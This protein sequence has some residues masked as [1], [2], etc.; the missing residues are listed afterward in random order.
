MQKQRG[1]I[2]GLI[3]ILWLPFATADPSV[4]QVHHALEV[5]LQPDMAAIEVRDTITLPQGHP[6]S[7]IFSLHPALQP[8]LQGANARLVE[9]PQRADSK[10]PAVNPPAGLEPRRYRLD[11]AGGE[12]RFTLH[13]SGSIAHTLHSRGE[14]YARSFEETRGIISPQGVF[15]SGASAW[16]PLLDDTLVTFDLEVSL[17]EAWKSM[18]QGESLDPQPA[19]GGAP[20]EHW[21]DTTPQEEIYLIAGPFT[22]YASVDAGIDASINTSTGAG[23]TAMVLLREPD[24]ALAQK[25]LDATHEYIALYD[26]LIG[27][28]PFKKFALVE[29]FWETGYGMPSFTLLGSRVIRFPFILSSSYPH[30]ILH[31]WWG[32]GVY[33]DYDSGNWAEGLTSYLADH[34]IKE[35]RGAGS[36]YRRNTLQ[37]YTDHVSHQRDFPLTAFRSRHSARTEAVGYGK[38]LMLFHMLRQQLGDAVFQ[39]G[40]QRFYQRHIFRVAGFSEVQDSFA[41]VAGEPLDDFFQQWVQRT[42]APQLGIGNARAQPEGDGYRLTAVIE[43]TQAG[44]VYHVS[45]PV[46]IHMDGIEQAYQTRIN[47]RDR[48]QTLSLML[49]ARPTRLDVDPEFDVFRRLHRNEIPPAVSQ[50]MGAERVLVVIAEQT[51]AALKQAYQALAERWQ[52]EKPGQVDV[53]FDRELQQLPD[54]RAVWLFG[55]QNRLR[56]QLN[57]ALEGY[58]FVAS[59][60]SVRIAGT[61]LSAATHSLVLL[62]RQPQA[63]DQALGWLAADSAAALPGLGRKLPHYG[64]YS[65]LGF[66]GMEPDNVLKGQWPVVDSPLSVRVQQDDGT[67]VSFNPASLAPRKALVAPVEQ[68]SVARMQQDIAF[69]ADASLAGR[70]LGTPQLDR[71]ADYI[72]QQFKTAGLQPGGDNGSYYQAWQQPVAAL[73]ANVA[74]KNVIAVLP[75]SDPRYQGQ[76]L[77]IAAHYDHMGRGE[78]NGRRE[79]RGLIHPGA[80]D[81]ASGIAVM[82]ELAR[83]LKG[84]PLP[85]TLVFVAFTGEETG[86]LGSRHYVRHTEAYPIDAVIGMLNLDT[87][88]RLGD[89]PLILL[90]S[91]SANEWVHIFRGAGYSTGIPVKAVA[92]DFGSGD[93]TAFIEAGIPAVQFFSGSHEDFHRPGDTAEKLDY[94]GLARVARVLNETVRYLGEHP[95]PLHSTLA[96]T[97]STVAPPP[98]A[99]RRVSFGTVPDFSYS[100]NGVRLDDVRDGTP[101]ERAGLREGDIIIAVNEI[102]V[103]D[104]RTYAQAL[105]QLDPGDEIHVRYLRDGVENT[106]TTRVTER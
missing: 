95:E 26:A 81:N 86:L 40:L 27:P 92:D 30:E 50:A 21:R 23:V 9:L 15:L 66:S 51:P 6:S 29:N 97:R 90:G 45:L 17:P 83:S 87:V 59:G 18:S 94:D 2:V 106:L 54:D 63:P 33:V 58:D 77:V 48:Q 68:F 74:M 3:C 14:E 12:H 47:L 46:A 56:P 57:A 89:R 42:G 96:G 39:Q 84:K 11:L 82:L 35:Q 13:Y 64:R 55:W 91:G 5:T 60:D 99:T 10:M 69:L 105:K 102:A 8:Q 76:S 43:Q 19:T 20:T 28:Y 100:G 53:V 34:L 70:G 93:Q 24:A 71:V 1:F 52:E 61:M 7:L 98:S 41:A 31:N 103:N 25:Y 22:A 4:T 32:N 104:M 75:G 62:A 36:E 44:P 80:D 73:G 79:D 16:Y 49:S 88:G 65:Y 85:R 78:V 101:A 37:K 67:A 72:A 38:T